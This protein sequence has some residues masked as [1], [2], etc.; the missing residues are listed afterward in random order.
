MMSLT[1]VKIINKG[2]PLKVVLFLTVILMLLASKAYALKFNF[3]VSQSYEDISNAVHAPESQVDT[4]PIDFFRDI[5][6]ISSF[7]LKFNEES[8]ILKSSVDFKI[9]YLDYV[10]NVA[11]DL[12]RSD[13]KST[14]L[15]QI[16]PGYYSW[17]LVENIVHSE[18]EVS[19]VV[20]EENTQDVNEFLTGPRFNWKLGSSTLKLNSYINKYT[21]S[22]TDNDTTNLITD[23]TWRNELSSGAKLD[24]KY[25]T[26]YVSFDRDEIYDS[27][28]QSTIGA[29]LKYKKNTNSVDIFFGKTFLNSDTVIDNVFEDERITLT[30]D[31]TRYSNL[32]FS[33]STG[34]SSKDEAL[35]TG[36]TVLNGVFISKKSVLTYKRSSDVFGLELKI[37]QS[38]KSNIDTA[39]VD[40]KRSDEINFYRILASR[41][42]LVFTFGEIANSVLVGLD[43]YEDVTYVKKIRYIKRF[44]NKLSFS[45]YL[46]ELDVVSDN[47]N[48]Q[49]NDKRIGLTIS[50][51][52]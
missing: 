48:R 5:L 33:Y 9:N 38:E 28:D 26:K 24:M 51:E 47:A 42:K 41:S 12:T 29:G 1:G 23:L 7:F 22:S 37:T 14:F 15:W 10:D 18:K 43:N 39:T 35:A 3:G 30:R 40:N 32:S 34:L 49:F 44:N 16:T 50:I 21:Y 31:L 25:T 11:S 13:L 46:S 17:Y 19:L 2:Y 52:R 8:S 20:S 36:G 4:A 45:A 6:V 27:Y